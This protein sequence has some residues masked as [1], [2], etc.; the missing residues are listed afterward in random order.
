MKETTMPLAYIRFLEVDWQGRPVDPG[1]GRPEGGAPDQGLPGG[2]GE[3]DN[4]LPIPNPPPG[5]PGHLPS[6]PVG[7]PIIP[8]HP[9]VRWPPHGETD[10]DWGVTPT[11]NPPPGQPGHLPTVPPGWPTIPS[12]PWVPPRPVYPSHPIHRPGGGWDGRPVD[13]GWGVGE[14]GGVDNTL[15]GLPPVPPTVAP[16]Q[17]LVAVRNAAGTWYFASMPAGSVPAPLP[18]PPPTAQPKS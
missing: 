2:G 6:V 13:P 7:K 1:Y 5:Q 8:S 14:G 15:P 3:I 12:H 18:E 10:P 9:I 17:V 16:G 11:P 4:A